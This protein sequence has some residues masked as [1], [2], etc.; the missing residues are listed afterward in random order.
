MQ[1]TSIFTAAYAA[2]ASRGLTVPS[3]KN[4]GPFHGEGIEL[5][6]CSD[7]LADKAVIEGK[8][9]LRSLCWVRMVDGTLAAVTARNASSSSA[10]GNAP[11]NL[12]GARRTSFPGFVGGSMA[13]LDPSK[14]FEED[15]VVQAVHWDDIQEGAD[16]DPDD[17]RLVLGFIKILWEMGADP[18]KDFISQNSSLS[19]LEIVSGTMMH[20]SQRNRKSLATLGKRPV[21]VEDWY[22][23][24]S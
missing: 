20:A 16:T 10:G 24:K 21:T 15:E 13:N 19:E 11:L 3:F 5:T 2:I 18:A 8:S 12:W 14:M 1:F 6:F 7:P 17:L 4:Y 23:V 9:T 22:V